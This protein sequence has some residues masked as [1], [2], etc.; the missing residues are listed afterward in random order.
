MA[1]T[2]IGQAIVL[3]ERIITDRETGNK[4]LIDCYNTLNIRNFPTEEDLVVFVALTGASGDFRVAL[5]LQ[6]QEEDSQVLAEN[7]YSFPGVNFI[8]EITYLVRGRFSSP[9]LYRFSW[10]TH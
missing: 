4:S 8:H 9:G 6:G 2:P 7:D 1:D 10:L 5:H 3:C